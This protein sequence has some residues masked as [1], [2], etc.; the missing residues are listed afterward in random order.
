[1]WLTWAWGA[2]RLPSAATRRTRISSLLLLAT[3]PTKATRY[4]LSAVL[5]ATR[6]VPASQPGVSPVVEMR[7]SAGPSG[8][9]SAARR[10]PYTSK[11]SSPIVTS[12]PSHT[13]RYS[14]SAAFQATSG[15]LQLKSVPEPVPQVD[16]CS[17]LPRVQPSDETRRANT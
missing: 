7:S 14:L 6:G 11:T 13:T 12:S 8:V 10:C 9:P 1:M 16:S 17:W 15:C 4:S 5:C 2:G 3:S